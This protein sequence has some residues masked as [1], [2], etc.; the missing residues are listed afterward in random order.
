MTNNQK[1]IA[2]ILLGAAAGAL[3]TLFLQSDKG[4]E[5][6]NDLKDAANEVGENLS[7]TAN[8]I[9]EVLSGL[10]QK[11]EDFVEDIEN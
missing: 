2:G 8:T 4:K 9:N 5:M 1:F 7:N 6:L 10:S 3:A 11:S